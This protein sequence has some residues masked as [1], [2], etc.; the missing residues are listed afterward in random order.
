MASP[1]FDLTTTYFYIAGIAGVNPDVATIGSVSFAKYAVQVAL[2]YE[3]DAREIPKNF[4]TGYFAQGA[5]A[6][7][8]Y[9]TSIYGTEVFEVNDSLRKLV[10]VPVDL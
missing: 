5:D 10:R 9:P 2:Q 7:G 4:S 8:Q 6:P 1:A 3:I